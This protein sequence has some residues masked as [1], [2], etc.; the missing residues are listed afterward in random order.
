MKKYNR[1]KFKITALVTIITL[2]LWLMPVGQIFGDDVSIEHLGAIADVPGGEEYHLGTAEGVFVKDNIAYVAA[3][4]DNALTII[5]VTDPNNPDY[6]TSVLDPGVTGARSIFVDGDYAYVACQSSDAFSVIDVSTPSSPSASNPIYHPTLDGAQVISVSNNY[7]FVT[8]SEANAFSIWD[9]QDPTV[10]S[11]VDSFQA[12]NGLDSPQGLFISDEGYAYVA[13][14]S[15]NLSIFNVQNPKAAFPES[16]I[17]GL[18]NTTS[19]YVDGN[20]AYVT[21][22]DN[23]LYIINVTNKSSPSI[24]TSVDIGGPQNVFVSE[25]YAFVTAQGGIQLAVYDVGDPSDPYLAGS[26][27]VPSGH[28]YYLGGACGIYVVGNLVYVCSWDNALTI[29]S[30]E[31]VPQES[32][33]FIEKHVDN[34]EIPEGTTF[35]FSWSNDGGANWNPFTL[36]EFHDEGPFLVYELELVPE[37]EYQVKEDLSSKP[38]YELGQI[39]INDEW[40]DG[41]T[42]TFTA[43]EGPNGYIAFHNFLKNTHIEASLTHNCIGFFDFTPNGVVDVNI[44]EY[45]GGTQ[46]YGISLETDEDGWAFFENRDEEGGLI[47]DLV[48]GMYITAQY[49]DLPSDLDKDVILDDIFISG[50]DFDTDRVWGTAPPGGVEVMVNVYS[51]EEDYTKWVTAEDNGDWSATFGD[52]ITPEMEVAARTFDEDLDETV[53]EP[54]KSNIIANLTSNWIEIWG[55]KP[56]ENVD[57]VINGGEPLTIDTGSEGERF[58]D[59]GEFEFFVEPGMNIVVVGVVSGITKV[60]DVADLT[61]DIYFL[62]SDI[63]NGTGPAN[64][65]LMVVIGYEEYFWE[66]EVQAGP[67]G[68]WFADFG[69]PEGHD[70]DLVEYMLPSVWHSDG[71]DDCTAFDAEG[72]YY[73]TYTGDTLVQYPNQVRLSA[74][75]ELKGD[76]GD[77]STLE[78]IIFEVYGEDYTLAGVQATVEDWASDGLSGTAELI[79]YD[80][81]VGVY[82][83]IATIDCDFYG[84]RDKDKVLL[85]VYDPSGGFATG[86]GCFT[87]EE[88][89][90]K[91]N[92]GFELKYKNDGTLKGNLNMIDHSSG[93]EYKET[94]FNFLVIMDN[95]AYFMGHVMIDGEGSYP[96]M[97][98]MEDNG[99]PGKNSD[100]FFISIQVEKEQIVFDEVIDNGNI[101][102][103]K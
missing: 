11:F 1:I 74:E 47:V 15:G 82:E 69:D 51:P 24:V 68:N 5:N 22:F 78:Y 45:Q 4:D 23:R 38:N 48:P 93:T 72:P 14:N 98:I 102:I 49:G 9:V 92:F 25:G 32:Y 7:A 40:V 2:F 71:E 97:A 44:Y 62:D 27:S 80:V 6:M 39:V 84:N 43:Q 87:P 58:L 95:K 41:E 96:F 36:D 46:L 13:N 79:L 83:V 17:G 19:V 77:V 60:L 10:P 91:V 64:E 56:Y 61:I 101:V 89:Q 35:D 76:P 81:P 54:P 12:V 90:E 16:Y 37:L 3:S 20:Y 34:G 100:E 57:I 66:M 67:D 86:G 18:G 26:T 103:H 33:I 88:S 52:D 28:P 50:V 94:D 8:A 42:V 31:E 85:A 63:V 59:G 55:F 65:W 29:F 73:I 21:S 75:V 70:L 99:T 53:V 30:V